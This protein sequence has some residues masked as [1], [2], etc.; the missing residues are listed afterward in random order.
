MA[1][2]STVIAAESL[3]GYRRQKYLIMRS[4]NW[5]G[6]RLLWF[7]RAIRLAWQGLLRKS[8]CLSHLHY[9]NLLSIVF[10]KMAEDGCSF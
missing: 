2:K 8:Q 10:I 7:P 5:I 6:R 4:Y 9:F 1:S 3:V